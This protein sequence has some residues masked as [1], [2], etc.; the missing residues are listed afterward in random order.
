MTEKSMLVDLQTEIHALSEKVEMISDRLAEVLQ[1]T[2]ETRSLVGPFGVPLPNDLMLVQTI[3]GVKFLIDPNDRI[4]APNLIIY[5]QWEADLSRLFLYNLNTSSVVV[6]VGANFGYF[7]CLSGNKIGNSGTGRIFAFEPNPRLVP[8]LR[9]NC[10]INWSMAP[11]QIHPVAVG[12]K[13]GR[14]VISI[15]ANGAANATLTDVS[16]DCDKVEI[17]VVALDDAL[18][19]DIVVDLLKIDVEG[20]EL[21]V[22]QGAE[23]LIR[24][25]PTLAIVMEWS[26]KQLNDAGTS[27]KEMISVIENLGLVAKSVPESGLLADAQKIDF[28]NLRDIKYDNIILMK[29]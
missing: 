3:H 18:P 6:D 25:S 24:R 22:L 13:K 12:A 8:L 9:D 27:P 28:S 23:K 10:Q 17:D 19:A 29:C 7:T 26:A 4:M 14:A 21:A 20:H 11:I 15:P 5:R 16:G 1:S 2:R